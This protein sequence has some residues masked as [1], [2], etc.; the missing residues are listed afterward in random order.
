MHGL[1]PAISVGSGPIVIASGLAY[2]VPHGRPEDAPFGAG[3]QG[4]P[5]AVGLLP[6]IKSIMA[7][8]STVDV[9]GGNCWEF[10]GGGTTS[11][12]AR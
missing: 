6:K 5:V 12:S 11:R 9:A 3:V 10:A 7:T 2:L 1:E 4:S 8:H